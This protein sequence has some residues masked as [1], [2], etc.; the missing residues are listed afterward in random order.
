MPYGTIKVDTVTFTNDGV[1]KSVTISGLVQNPTFSGNVTV[2][3]TVSG[4][5]IRGQTVS[6]ATITGGAAAFTTITGGVATITSGVFALGSASNPSISFSGDSNTGLYSPGADQV[7]ISTGG[8][9]RLFVDSVGNVGIGTSSPGSNLHVAGASASAL[10]E[11]TGGTTADFLIGDGTVRYYGIRSVAGGGSLQIR[12]HTANTTLATFTSAGLVGIGTSSPSVKLEVSGPAGSSPEIRCVDGTVNSQW[13]AAND[14]TCVFGTFSNHPQ[15]F[16]TNGSERL[17]ITSAGLVGIGT[18]SPA[19]ALDVS[20]STDCVVRARVNSNTSAGF[21]GSTDNGSSNW[22]FGARKDSIGGSSGTDRFNILYGASPFLT[23]ATGG[24]VGIGTTTPNQP[25][26]VNGIIRGGS[27]QFG[28]S[29]TDVAEYLGF[30]NANGPSL[31]FWGSASANAGA[32][33]AKTAGTERLRIDSSGNVGIGTT[34]PGS[35]LTIESSAGNQVKI[36]YPSIASYFLNATSGGDFAINKD[37]TER[38]RIDSSGRLLVNTSTGTA[39][40]EVLTTSNQDGI[41]LDYANTPVGNVGAAISFAQYNNGS[42]MITTSSVQGVLM[43][44]SVGTE[45]GDLVFNTSIGGAAPAERMRISSAG[46]V[47]VGTTDSSPAFNNVQ[48]IALD[49]ANG[50]IASCRDGNSTATFGRKTNDGDIVEFFQDGT[51]EGTISVSGT[52]VSY[53]GA[54][55]SRWSQ[56]PNGAEREEILRGSVLSNIDEMCEWTDEENEQLNRMK[57]SDVEGDKNVSGVFQGWDDDDD[58]Y[59]NDFYCAM[60]GDFIIRIGNG[61][62]VERGDLLMSAGDGTAK[63]QDD[64]IIRSKTIAKVTST[65]VS[66]TYDDGSYCVPCVLMAC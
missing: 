3:G 29:G 13:Y 16:R 48:G 50:V 39:K 38:A 10:I 11:A 59:T 12:N 58:T 47:T 33:I 57:V 8:S 62:T 27:Y 32:F 17:R 40:L 23:I 15:V 64:D 63:P 49:G 41:R 60:T 56:L 37:G 25:L 18:S 66:C 54:H 30:S 19:F 52:T 46:A 35:P 1:D 20:A 22:F 4:N 2:T 28:T 42:S 21:V 44:G 34:S 61:V 31:N 36:T 5:T 45:A 51:K 53:N 65:N 24:N 43:V 14:G 55:L 6:G 9:G 26:E 7:A